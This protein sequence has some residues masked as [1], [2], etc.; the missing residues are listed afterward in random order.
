MLS[1]RSRRA[2][3]FALATLI[4]AAAIEAGAAVT[5]RQLVAR[6]WMA[7]IPDLTAAQIAGYFTVVD[8]AFGWGPIPPAASGHPCASA[9]GDSFTA[10]AAADHESYPFQ[11]GLLLGCAVNNYG[12][13]GYGSDQAEM[14]AGYQVR[15]GRDTA[16]LKLLG[17]VSE[18]ILRN[19]NRYRNLLYPGQELFF[20]P[21]YVI[22]GAGLKVIPTVFHAAAEFRALASPETA[23]RDDAFLARPRREFPYTLALARW[24]FTDFHVRAKL[25]RTPRHQPFYRP[26]HP[27]GALALTTRILTQFSA[28]TGGGMVVLIP[29]GDDFFYA[30]RTGEWPDQPLA[31]ALRGARV[32]VIHAGPAMLAR[33]GG[34]DPCSLFEVCNGHYNARG[35][36]L[37]AEIVAAAIAGAGRRPAPVHAAP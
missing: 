5:T 34:T 11:L 13:G 28:E 18:N 22:D 35:K 9:Y 31:D 29:V 15:T 20:K 17:H 25:A 7:A 23:L 6:G 12:V 36:R 27:S 30:M 1:S 33:L 10:G 19:V 2:L 26:D 4:A 8:A 16:P 24:L 14:L 3:F 21:R 32:P 37:L